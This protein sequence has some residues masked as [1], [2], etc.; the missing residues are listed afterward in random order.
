MSKN[1]QK[2]LEWEEIS[3][4]HIIN[5]KWIDFRQVDYRLPDGK[6]WQPFYN[7]SRKDFVVILASDRD[8]NYICVRQFRYG[9][10]EVTTEFPAGG[11]ES[12]S[13]STFS[14]MGKPKE[15]YELALDTAKR[16][17]REETG[18]ESNDWE[19]MIAVPSNATMADNYGFIYRA[20]NCRCVDKQELDDT[21]FL[22]VQLY[23]GEE[24]EN[25]IKT[26]NFQQALH[27]LAWEMNR[28]KK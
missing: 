6:I 26:G 15:Y 19:F 24:I 7:Y 10:G 28:N 5:D 11:I 12:G 8:D 22:N 1:D 23:K 27:I 25:L 20:K 3:V 14:H 13:L 9:V 16:E 2:N 4:D 21:E 18:Y 17:L